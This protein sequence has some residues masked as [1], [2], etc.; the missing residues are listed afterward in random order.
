MRISNLIK[1]EKHNKSQR[2]ARSTFGNIVCFAFL[3]LGGLFSMI[4]LLYAIIS[5]FK[6]LDELMV[7]PPRFFVHR[8]T[9]VNYVALPDLLTDLDVPLSRYVLNSILI[10][11]VTTT[12]FIF[13]SSMA[14]FSL[15]KGKFRGKKAVFWLVQ[16]A[17]MFNAYTLSIPQYLIYSKI[18]IIDTYWVY[19]LPY[20]ASTLGVFLVK[21]YIEGYVPDAYLEAARI[22]GASYYRIFWSIVMPI[23]RPVVMT[24]ILFSFRDIWSTVPNGTIFKEELKTLPQVV[25]QITAGGMARAGSAMAITSIMMLPPIIVYMVTQRSVVQVMSSAGIKE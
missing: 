24:L 20:L 13:I 18:H 8:P 14:A 3:L 10:S 19:I 15:S 1:R 17:L 9:I 6:P 5:S 21:Q 23:I 12:V 22:D 16:L 25:S 7:F 4:P 2:F 11:V